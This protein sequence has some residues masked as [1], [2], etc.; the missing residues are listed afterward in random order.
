M[1][2]EKYIADGII[3]HSYGEVETYAKLNGY[4][5]TNTETLRKGVYLITLNR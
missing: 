1:K 4:R 2:T 3:F 5:V